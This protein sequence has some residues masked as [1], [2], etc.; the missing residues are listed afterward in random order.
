MVAR[1]IAVGVLVLAVMLAVKDG[2]LLQAS[3]LRAQCI[4]MQKG[5]DGATLEACRSGKFESRP[6]LTKRGCLDAGLV[7]S[8]EYW[9]CPAART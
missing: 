9:H 5:V 4:V 6:D 7:G 3:G 8:Y 1:V 2:R